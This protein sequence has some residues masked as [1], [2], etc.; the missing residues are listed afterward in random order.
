MGPSYEANAVAGFSKGKKR[1]DDV[2]GQGIGP[3]TTCGEVLR[4]TALSSLAL[5]LWS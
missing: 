3:W 4:L 2:A 1:M 5:T